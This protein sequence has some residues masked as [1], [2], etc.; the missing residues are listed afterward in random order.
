MLGLQ[1]FINRKLH[2]VLSGI[3]NASFDK[4]RYNIFTNIIYAEHLVYST[5]SNATFP[6]TIEKVEAR[7]FHR[8]SYIREKT[9]GFDQLIVEGGKIFLA[10]GLI[11]NR[12]DAKPLVTNN[13]LRVDEIILRNIDIKLLDGENYMVVVNDLQARIRTPHFSNDPSSG[14]NDFSFRTGNIQ[15]SLPDS[16]FDISI[17]STSYLHN[18]HSLTLGNLKYFTSVPEE[19]W[20]DHN[21]VKRAHINLS[22][23]RIQVDDLFCEEAYDNIV[24]ASPIIKVYKPICTV[25][26]DGRFIHCDTCYQPLLQNGLSPILE[27]FRID[28]VRLKNGTVSYT[29]LNNPALDESKLQF[30]NVDAVMITDGKPYTDG[31]ARLMAKSDIFVGTPLLLDFSFDLLQKE[32]TFT[33]VGEIGKFQLADLNPFLQ[34]VHF[35]KITSGQA[36]KI[37][38]KITGNDVANSGQ[39]RFEYDNLRASFLNDDGRDM[40]SLINELA[41]RKFNIPGP[42]FRVGDLKHSRDTSRSL[43][44]S[45]SQSLQAGIKSIALSDYA[46]Q[47]EQHKS[48]N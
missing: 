14:L 24:C 18:E 30:S 3:N 9:I 42:H 10:K 37:Q 12:H 40:S 44:H 19:K 23:E 35:V 11:K 17:G 39:M 34:G 27:R 22:A 47:L 32:N 48:N 26:E 6:S 41:I 45:L 38:F 16:M 13:N 29:K 46:Q 36:N 43:F 15:Y 20:F 5:D 25:F 8:L 31:R 7:G 4:I 28:T 2:T 21:P 1:Y 33:L